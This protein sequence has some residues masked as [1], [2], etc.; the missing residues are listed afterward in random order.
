[1]EDLKS[2]KAE[3]SAPMQIFPHE[4]ILGSLS[5]EVFSLFSDLIYITSGITL[6]INKKG[7]LISRLGKRMQ[8]RGIRSFSDYYQCVKSDNEE[9]IQM[10]NCIS[11]NT[12]KFFRENYHFAYLKNTVIPE[13]IKNNYGSNALRIWSAGCSTGEEPYSIAIAVHEAL[14]ANSHD[15]NEWDIKILATDISTKVLD[16]AQAGIYEYDQLPED[17]PIDAVTKFFLKGLR[18]NEGKIKIKDFIK[19]TVIFRRLNLKDATYPFKKTFDI[20]FCRNVMIYFDDNMRQHVISKFHN[21]LSANGYLFLGHSETM[22][23]RDQFIPV[24]VTV[25]RKN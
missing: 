2:S 17:L 14:T 5:D 20:I 8:K 19:R 4:N 3:F 22:F 13:L 23:G 7:L 6:N 1:M 11:T 21:Y 16:T 10:L 25:Y 9:L 18:E 12:T 15:Y 24:F